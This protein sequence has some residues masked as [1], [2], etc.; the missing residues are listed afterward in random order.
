MFVVVS[1]KVS[2]LRLDGGPIPGTA[3]TNN[4]LGTN[5]IG[6]YFTVTEVQHTV[7]HVSPIVVFE[8]LLFGKGNLESYGYPAGFRLAPINDV[9]PCYQ[10]TAKV[11][12]FFFNFAL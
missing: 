9:C 7:Y 1:S 4:I 11:A 2:G 12:R 5:L 3:V 6:G 8:C 10:D